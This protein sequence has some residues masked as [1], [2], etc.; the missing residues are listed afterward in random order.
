MNLYSDR[1]YPGGLVSTGKQSFNAQKAVG[2]TSE[3][4]NLNPECAADSGKQGKIMK[5]TAR[6]NGKKCKMGMDFLF[7]TDI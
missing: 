4:R 1:F 6:N 2:I 5:G 3:Q 7:L